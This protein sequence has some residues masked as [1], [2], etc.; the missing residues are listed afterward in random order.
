MACGKPVVASRIQGT[1]DVFDQSEAIKLVAPGDAEM[2]SNV[3]I[4]LL[5]N[6]DEA[7]RMGGK[8]HAFILE[9]YDRRI[10]AKRTADEAFSFIA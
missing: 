3:I 6:Q 10:I 4:D 5:A 8:G 1:T 2:L 9:K 7:E